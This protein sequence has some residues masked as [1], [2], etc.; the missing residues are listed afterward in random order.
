MN[1]RL[2]VIDTGVKPARWNIAFGQALADL[3]RSGHISETLRFLRFP[4]SA[5]IGRHQIMAREVNVEWCRQNG[6]ELARRITGGGAIYMEPAQLGWEL[7]LPRAALPGSLADAAAFL[8]EAAAQGLRQLG[9]AARFR[10]RND[11]EVE[12]RKISGTGG[13]FDGPMLFYQGTVL[14]EFNLET[15]AKALVLPTAKLGR[16]GLAELGE[17]VTSLAALLGRPP[18]LERVQEVLAQSFSQA[19]RLVPHWSQVSEVETE[20]AEWLLDKE[21]GTDAFVF[22]AVPNIEAGQAL[23]GLK[24]SAGGTIEARARLHPSLDGRVAQVMFTGDFFA[25]PPRL[26]PDL[27]AHLKDR[28]VMEAIDEVERFFAG[29]EVEAMSAAPADF[30]AALRNAIVGGAVDELE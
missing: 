28:P 13:F 24:R 20:V 14:I 4:R 21:I 12:G 5:L 17:R 10:P 8:C 26:I 18:P 16:R 2:R 30:Q 15:M 22:D 7:A 27:E 9:V 3:C 23:C 19:L 1:A 25:A 29:R 6:L 11:I